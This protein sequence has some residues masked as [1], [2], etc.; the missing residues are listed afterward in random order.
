MG[1]TYTRK[2]FISLVATMV[3]TLA[4]TL[5]LAPA[6]FAASVTDP[7]ITVSSYN[8]APVV[9][10]SDNAQ[11]VVVTIDYGETV[12]IESLNNVMSGLTI[13]IAGYD[14]TSSTYY[15]PVE[16][17]SEGSELILDIGNRE[18]NGANAF[19]AIYGG[20]IQISGTPTGVMVDDEQVGAIASSDSPYKT[21]IPTG[22]HIADTKGSSTNVVTAT[23]DSPAS[24]RGMVHVVLYNKTTVTNEDGSQTVT[25]TPVNSNGSS[26][27][28]L[29]VGAVVT[30]AHNFMTLTDA[31]YAANISSALSAVLPTGYS[32]AYTSGAES[33]TVT[34]PVGTD[35][36]VYVFDDVML[37][38]LGMSF[39]GVVSNA[40]V[41]TE[42]L[43]A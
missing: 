38:D 23:V 21:V 1:H 43:P 8:V 13:K 31:N 30:H 41:W 3:A 17:R 14:I 25:Y 33:F 35:L 29:Q 10:A 40:G 24:I 27:G 34:G 15:R 39:T 28:N 12:E 7:D 37:K 4:L 16:V 11:H 18:S 42:Y 19:T 5:T 2:K 9:Y 36:Y 22:V 26:S 32:I 20:V 6:A